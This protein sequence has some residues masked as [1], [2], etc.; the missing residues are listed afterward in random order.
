MDYRDIIAEETAREP[1]NEIVS[2]AS[3]A[4]GPITVTAEPPAKKTEPMPFKFCRECGAKINAKAEICPKCGV[5]IAATSEN[6]IVGYIGRFSTEDFI[7]GCIAR[8]FGLSSLL[9][10]VTGFLTSLFVAPI[11]ISIFIFVSSMFSLGVMYS[12]MYGARNLGF[13][14]IFA[15]VLVLLGWIGA[16]LI[17]STGF[18][19]IVYGVRDIWRENKV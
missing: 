2:S 4:S 14:A 12:D 11:F 17:E 7:A 16:I 9:K 19:M 1:Q 10:I 6:F 3:S 18:A 13:A 5:R 15:F 8:F